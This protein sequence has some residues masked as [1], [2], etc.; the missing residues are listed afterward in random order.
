[1]P[2]TVKD[3]AGSGAYTTASTFYCLN[4]KGVSQLHDR[5]TFGRTPDT[6][7]VD[8]QLAYTSD[9]LVSNGTLK[10]AIDVFNAFNSSRAIEQYEIRDYSRATSNAASG[11]QL[12]ANYGQPT[13]FQ[14][15]RYFRM[16]ARYTF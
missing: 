2:P 1:M 4:D 16:S 12:N 3:F 7:Q 6:A 15:P 5:G 13:S 10:F 8:L 9:E 14:T 11:N